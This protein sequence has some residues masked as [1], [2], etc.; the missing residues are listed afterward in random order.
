[1][2]HV[3]R[4]KR[5]ARKKKRVFLFIGKVKD[6]KGNQVPKDFDME[7]YDSLILQKQEIADAKV[8]AEEDKLVQSQNW[9][10]LRDKLNATNQEAFSKMVSDKDSALNDITSAYFNEKK[11]N[12]ITKAL[13]SEK[14]NAKLLLPHIAPNLDVIK[15]DL[16]GYETVVVDANGTRRTMEDTGDFMTITNLVNQFKADDAFSTAFPAQ[17][18]GSGQ[19]AVVQSGLKGG[20]NPFKKGK[21]WNMTEQAA[22][23]RDNP[24]LAKAMEKVT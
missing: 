3:P 8:K 18:S 13:E 20:K 6:L 7:E 21:G 9:D 11:S 12:D 17:D 5:S 4:A 24:D 2:S 1:M 15:N 10:T 22:M 16:G 23:R 14:A 19:G